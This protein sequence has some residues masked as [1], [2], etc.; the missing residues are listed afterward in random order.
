[1]TKIIACSC[2]HEFQ[3]SRYGK[4]FRVHNQ[5]KNGDWRCTVCKQE[6]K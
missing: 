3:D 1:M 4:G 2:K 5:K 6:K